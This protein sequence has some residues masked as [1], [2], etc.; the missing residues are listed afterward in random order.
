LAEKFQ[1][2]K[3]V[4]RKKIFAAQKTNPGASVLGPLETG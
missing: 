3:K 2:S 4:S 1:K